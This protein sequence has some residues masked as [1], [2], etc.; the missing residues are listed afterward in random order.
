MQPELVSSA[1][2]EVVSGSGS[3]EGLRGGGSMAVRFE[4][5]DPDRGPATFTGTIGK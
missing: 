4:S 3:F 1:L 5:K 2:W